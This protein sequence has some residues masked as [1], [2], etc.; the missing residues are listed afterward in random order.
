MLIE[1]AA[2]G[3]AILSDLKSEVRGLVPV[4]TGGLS[5]E[6]RLELVAPMFEAGNV[7]LPHPAIAPW[8]GE[9][10]EEL[11]TF[12]NSE[13]NDLVDSTSQALDRYRTARAK[14]EKKS[15]RRY[16][17]LGVETREPLIH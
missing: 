1:E 7:W 4:S 14:R 5:K 10:V 8:V 13:H 12:P 16:S 11:V 6:A 2:N 9:Y 17:M 15:S 3:H